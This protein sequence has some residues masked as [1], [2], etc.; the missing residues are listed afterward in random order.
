MTVQ[1]AAV[2][3][4]LC[5]IRVALLVSGALATGS[6]GRIIPANSMAAARAKKPLPPRPLPPPPPLGCRAKP[7]PQC[8][9]VLIGVCCACCRTSM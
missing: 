3:H 4:S 7:P 5:A 2:R 8:S 9:T 1:A 6:S